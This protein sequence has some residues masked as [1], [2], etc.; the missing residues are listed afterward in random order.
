MLTTVETRRTGAVTREDLLARAESLIPALRE[1]AE[2][3]EKAGKCP[4]ETVRDY[5]A[6]D[7]LRV[8]QPSR[9]GGFDMG[10]DVLCEIIQTLA[11]GDG[12]QAWTYMVLADNPLKLAAYEI[13]AQDDV[14]KEDDTKR[15][16]VAVSPVGRARAVDGGV[17]WNGEHGFCSGVDHA[18][19]VMC[20]GFEYDEAGRKG[21]GL[22]VV[23]P[24]SDIEVIDDWRVIGLAGTG[25]K[26]FKVKDVFVPAHRILD[27]AAND[28]GR[29]PGTL[30]YTAPVTRLPRGGVSAVTYTAVVVGVAQG[31][32]EEF[33]KITGPR[34]SRNGA[35]AAH[36]AIQASVGLASAEI[37]AAERMYLGAVR[38][39]MQVLE[40]GETCSE[41]MQVQGKRNACYAA[42]LC[43][44]AVQR[45]F[46]IAGG[47]AL[48]VDSPLQRMF[49]DCFAAAAHHSLVWETAAADYG[50][51]ALGQPRDGK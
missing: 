39:T 30:Y 51:W 2:A 13:A 6:N 36:G 19:W 27:K 21:R 26:S 14:W 17:V 22:S 18:D 31:F 34:K 40:R 7:L 38:E 49:R 42:Q 44:Q 20:G 12:S 33:L 48:Y 46:N 45:L 8:C 28:A 25:S 35:V 9:Y 5:V 15:L 41:Q 10:Y 32:L 3:G 4:D 47:R 23:V 11:R 29:G 24:K 1:R 37:E 43:L 50:R 16:T